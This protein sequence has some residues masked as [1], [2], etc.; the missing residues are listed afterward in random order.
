MNGDNPKNRPEIDMEALRNRIRSTL[1]DQRMT[2]QNLSEK[3]GIPKSTLDSFLNRGTTPAFDTVALICAVLSIPVDSITGASAP[4][5]PPEKADPD[6]G[7]LSDMKDSHIREINSLTELHR[8]ETEALVENHRQAMEVLQQAHAAEN[9][10]RDKHIAEISRDRGVWRVIAITAIV[11]F[12][13]ML[14]VWFIWDISH[15]DAGLILY[16]RKSML[17]PLGLG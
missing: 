14:S 9:T 11:L 1:S 13:L 12:V 8:R 17:G 7:R 16:D 2:V 15:P 4:A 10:A 3:T 6:S 5:E